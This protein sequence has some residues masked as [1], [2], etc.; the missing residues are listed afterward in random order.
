M[1]EHHVSPNEHLKKIITCS[2]KWLMVW[3]T[4]LFCRM[5]ASILKRNFLWVKTL[6]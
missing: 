5:G 4:N 2:Q 1:E 3:P 6:L